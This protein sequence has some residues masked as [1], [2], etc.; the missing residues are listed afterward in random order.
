MVGH[1]PLKQS[2]LVRVQVPQ[3]I[4]MKILV[5]G[6]PGSGKT[7][8]VEY[9]QSIGDV[10]FV[11]ADELPGLCE[12][13][14]FKTGEVLGLVT[15]YKETGENEW[16][17]KYGWYWRLDVLAKFLESNPNSII[18]GSSENVVEAYKYFNKLFVLKKTEEE[19]ILN[20]ENPKRNNP[21]GR[22]PEQRKNFLNW[23]DY[24][25]KEAEP[26]RL[27]IIEGN[28]V[29]SRYKAIVDLLPTS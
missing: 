11:D 25:I 29:E 24:L 6:T 9:A 3:Q 15:E 14:E 17:E 2:I 1:L 21:F 23:Q 10:R 7:A 13:R 28:Q 27:T 19:L 4:F 16:Y 26:Y 18:C 8:L 5:T 12:W 22:T 20:L